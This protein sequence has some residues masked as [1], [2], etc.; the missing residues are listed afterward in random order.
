MLTVIVDAE[1][2]TRHLP[3]RSE[4]VGLL[5]LDTLDANHT[6]LNELLR[7]REGIE[8]G[9]TTLRRVLTSAGLNSPRHRRSHRHSV[10]R[11]RMPR[12]GCCGPYYFDGATG[13]EEVMEVIAFYFAS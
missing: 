11:Q 3:L 7:E 2:P 4:V 12:E 1:H 9:R 8:I 13:R 5:N 6:H 10:R